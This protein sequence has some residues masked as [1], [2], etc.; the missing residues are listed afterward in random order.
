MQ[1]SLVLMG[2]L[3]VASYGDSRH[4]L[5]KNRKDCLD[6]WGGNEQDC[7]EPDRSSHYYRSGYWYGPRYGQGG[8]RAAR[9]VGSTTVSRG[10][11]GSLGSFHAS[12]GG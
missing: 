2:T 6:D 12:F 5:Y 3:A 1:V 4:Y 11:F 10:G 9:A 7:R 8:V